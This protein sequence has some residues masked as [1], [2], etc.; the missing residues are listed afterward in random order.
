MLTETWW[1]IGGLLTEIWVLYIMYSR[2]V[3]YILYNDDMSP[4]SQETYTFVHFYSA[5]LGIILVQ[6]LVSNDLVF[7]TSCY[8]L[9]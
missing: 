9:I 4:R 8:L 3:G 6:T 7:Y 5:R 2:D 1:T